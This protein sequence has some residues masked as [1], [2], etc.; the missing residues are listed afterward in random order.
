M[1]T[2]NYSWRKAFLCAVFETDRAKL[3]AGISKA[4]AAIEA[5]VAVRPQPDLIECRAI[6]DARRSLVT[7]AADLALIPASL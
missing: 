2:R 6:E 1:N 3:P 5:R 4:T 7:L